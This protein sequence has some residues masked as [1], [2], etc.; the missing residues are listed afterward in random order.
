MQLFCITWPTWLQ[1]SLYLICLDNISRW[2]RYLGGLNIQLTP[3][4][5]MNRQFKNVSESPANKTIHFSCV[6]FK[7]I[8]KVVLILK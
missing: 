6:F 3:N 1:R 4:I 8:I 2:S 5:R 7:I